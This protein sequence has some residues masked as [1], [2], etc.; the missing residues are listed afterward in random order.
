MTDGPGDRRTLSAGLAR[1]ADLCAVVAFALVAVAA[2]ATVDDPAVRALVSLPLLVALPGY[3]LLALLSASDSR[4]AVDPTN[5]VVDV[6]ATVRDYARFATVVTA[7][8]LLSTLS[9]LGLVAAPGPATLTGVVAILAGATAVLAALA[10]LRRRRSRSGRPAGPIG[11]GRGVE[12]ES[13]DDG[14]SGIPT[15]FLAL[16]AAF[17]LVTVAYLA[18][19]A[20]TPESYSTLSVHAPNESGSALESTGFVPGER[21]TFAVGVENHEREPANYTLVARLEVVRGTGDS[22]TVLGHQRVSRYE[23]T[24]DAGDRWERR[25]EVAPRE[26]PGRLRVAYYLYRGAPP[27]SPSRETAYRTAVVWAN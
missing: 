22:A 11:G 18:V 23:F 13:D 24:L 4:G 25:H 6:S 7:S 19:F 16:T 14:G 15:A 2:S 8:L 1:F 12:S 20:P 9:W 5:P 17:L 3:A 10:A 21:S 26:S 27:A